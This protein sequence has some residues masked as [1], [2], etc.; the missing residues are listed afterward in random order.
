[1]RYVKSLLS[2]LVGALL[3]SAIWV[4]AVFVLPL[5]VPVLIGRFTGSGGVATASFSSGP[6]VLVAMVGFVAGAWW[7]L[8]RAR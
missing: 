8:R 5:V 2:G 3:A 4:L 6:L 7:G 1:M